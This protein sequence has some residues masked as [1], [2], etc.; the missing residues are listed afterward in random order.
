[1]LVANFVTVRPTMSETHTYEDFWKT[2]G[3]KPHKL[4]IMA[5]LYPDLT[6]PFI[7]ESL[8]NIYYKSGKPGR[9]ESI[10][11]LM[12][13]WEIETNYIKLVRFADAPDYDPAADSGQEITFYFKERYYEKYDIFMI[14]KSRQQV[15][16]TQRPVRKADDYWAVT[17]RLLDNDYNSQLD[18][19]ACGIDDPTRFQSN[20]HPELSEEGYIK[21]QSSIERHRN[22]MTYFRNDAS[23]SSIYGALE[24]VFISIADG[25]GQGDYTERIYKMNKIEKNLVENFMYA[26]NTGMLFNKT[27]MNKEGKS[28]IQDPD[29][30]RPIVI[31]DGLVPQIERFASKYSY[32][33]LTTGVLTTAMSVMREKCAKDEGNDWLFICNSKLWDDIQLRLGSWLLSFTQIGTYLWDRKEN[34]YIQVGANYN[35]YKFAGNVLTFKVD[36]A[37]TREFGADKGFGLIIDLTADKAEGKPAV[38]TYTLKGGDFIMN[39][40]EGV[41]RLDGVS[42]G[43]VAS[44]VAG[45]KLIA[46][47]YAGIGVF[48]PYRSFILYEN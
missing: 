6:V 26:R 34:D 24:D 15:I 38:A 19:S 7:T 8:W 29:T 2:F 32:G 40:L 18:E 3:V 43:P 30:G 16:V 46:T 33:K 21:Y 20:A 9:F 44:P 13:D 1:M 27:S 41:G 36:R 14:L 17:G 12:F 11:S 48:A 22:Y 37:F 47:G 28:T 4:G 23:F 31:G 25:K 10:E 5:K 45:S 35:S 42:S 39:R